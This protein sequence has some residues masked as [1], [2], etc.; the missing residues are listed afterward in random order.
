MASPAISKRC[1]DNMVKGL[2][3]SMTVNRMAGIIQEKVD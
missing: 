1:R 2:G 3:A